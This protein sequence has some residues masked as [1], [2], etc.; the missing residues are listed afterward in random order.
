MHEAI[1][2]LIDATELLWRFELTGFDVEYRW[3][4]VADGWRRF[5]GEHPSP[6]AD[7]HMAVRNAQHAVASGC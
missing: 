2:D 7:V 1:G 4:P 5:L 3:R 6:N